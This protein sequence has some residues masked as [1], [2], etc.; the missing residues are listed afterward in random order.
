MIFRKVNWKFVNAHIIKEQMDWLKDWTYEIVR[1]DAGH[2]RTND[3]NKYL[4]WAVYPAIKEWLHGAYDTEKIHSIM[5]LKFLV[6]TDWKSPYIKSTSRLT[7]AEFSEYVENIK[8]FVAD[9][10]IYIPTAEEYR[11][12]M[13]GLNEIYS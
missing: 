4:W 11:K 8:N 7:T 10:G 2:W 9:F 5:A 12:W 1:I 3:Q 6:A 13:E